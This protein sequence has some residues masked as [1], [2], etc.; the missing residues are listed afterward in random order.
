MIKVF[1][2]SYKFC[3]YMKNWTERRD[4][5]VPV[6]AIN[7]PPV[8]DRPSGVLE[9]AFNCWQQYGLEC[10]TIIWQSF[11]PWSKANEKEKKDTQK[12]Q[13]EGAWDPSH[14]SESCSVEA[15]Q[16]AGSSSPHWRRSWGIDMLLAPTLEA[17]SASP[18]TRR[19]H[20]QHH[21]HWTLCP[22]KHC[23]S[24]ENKEY[25]HEHP[26]PVSSVSAPH[27]TTT[28]TAAEQPEVGRQLIFLNRCMQG[29]D[30]AHQL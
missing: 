1:E 13:W 26:H 5:C 2:T 15:E 19:C 17:R 30:Q 12:D 22:H 18:L 20:F 9:A 21:S 10:D 29:G 6:A 27:Y 3:P 7:L 25:R 23:A 28:T 16:S 24:P 8:T 4:F 14:P 11:P